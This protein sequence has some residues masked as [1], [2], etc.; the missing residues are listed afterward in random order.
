MKVKIAPNLLKISALVLMVLLSSCS[1][2]GSLEIDCDAFMEMPHQVDR[3]EV[4]EGDDFTF[5]LCSNPTTG[6]NWMEDAEI[7]DTGVIKQDHQE[8]TAP[9]QVDDPPPPGT[10]GTHTWIFSAIEPGESIIT[11]EYGQPWDGG[12]KK[13]WT[14]TLTVIVE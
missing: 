10:P 8:F 6:N 7:S 11:L 1:A 12:E 13:T 14:F 5:R 3:I 4:R 2:S 9:G